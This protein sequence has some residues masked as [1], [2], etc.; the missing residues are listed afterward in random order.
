MFDAYFKKYYVEFVVVLALTAIL[1]V[2]P[3]PTGG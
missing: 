2:I 1:V 3:I